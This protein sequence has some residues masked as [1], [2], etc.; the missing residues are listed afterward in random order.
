MSNYKMAGMIVSK[1]AARHTSLGEPLGDISNIPY[2]VCAREDDDL[3]CWSQRRDQFH[4]KANSYG[5]TT[6][7]SFGCEQAPDMRDFQKPWTPDAR[8]SSPAVGKDI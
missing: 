1:P 5:T 8:L 6:L 7:S 3:N 2:G 4:P